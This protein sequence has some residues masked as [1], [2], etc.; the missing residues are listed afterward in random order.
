[1]TEVPDLAGAVGEL[2]AAGAH[3]RNDV[4]TGIGTRQILLGDP[5]GNVV[6]LFEPVRHEARLTRSAG[7]TATPP[8]SGAD[9]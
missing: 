4:V 5:P 8:A 2:R 6:E 3:F 9:A 1:M 7:A